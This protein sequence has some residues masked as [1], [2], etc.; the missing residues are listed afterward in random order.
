MYWK[1]MWFEMEKESYEWIELVGGER[2]FTDENSQIRTA[3]I[4]RSDK[5]VSGVLTIRKWARYVKKEEKEMGVTLA[6][7]GFR[8][9]RDGLSL[10]LSSLTELIQELQKLEVWAR[11]EGYIEK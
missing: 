5:Q 2:V 7:T 1:G 8:P 11:T 9:T 10:P 4:E 6:E 3:I